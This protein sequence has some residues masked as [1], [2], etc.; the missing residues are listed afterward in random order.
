MLKRALLKCDCIIKQ[1]ALKPA[2]LEQKKS[3]TY[4]ARRLTMLKKAIEKNF[5]NNYSLNFF[6]NYNYIDYNIYINDYNH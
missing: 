3:E 2:Q 1:P 6:I 4:K 5:W